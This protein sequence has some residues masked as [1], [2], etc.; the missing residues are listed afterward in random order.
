VEDV[1][2]WVSSLGCQVM[3]HT[4]SP[5]IITVRTHTSGAQ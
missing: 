5:V 3:L 1:G 2:F 4:A